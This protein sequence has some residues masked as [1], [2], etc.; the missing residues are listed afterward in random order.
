ML[1]F[2]DTDDV[3]E[4]IGY[5]STELVFPGCMC[6]CLTSNSTLVFQA[7]SKFPGLTKWL[8][9]S[10]PT[11]HFSKTTHTR[12]FATSMCCVRNKSKQQVLVTTYKKDN[13]VGGRNEGGISACNTSTDKHLWDFSSAIP[14]M[15]YPMLPTDVTTDGYGRLLVCDANNQC[16]Q[17]FLADGSYLAPYELDFPKVKDDDV[18][19]PCYIRWAS[20]I[21]SFVGV[22]ESDKKYLIAV[23]SMQDQ[24]QK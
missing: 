19:I 11:P 17:M 22:M 10:G 2:R 1:E 24:D 20:D 7:A 3:D 14:E 4:I 9:C 12:G 8:D 6:A 18:G 23:I 16:L 15:E 21:S 5:F 13:G